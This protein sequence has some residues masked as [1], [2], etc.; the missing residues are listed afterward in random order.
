VSEVAPQYAPG[1]ATRMSDYARQVEILDAGGLSIGGAPLH[2]T[3]RV[4]LDGQPVTLAPTGC[5]PRG[6]EPSWQVIG[7]PDEGT[8]LALRVYARDVKVTRVAASMNQVYLG[9][10]LLLVPF[11]GWLPGPGLPELAG[12]APDSPVTVY[13]HVAEVLIRS[14]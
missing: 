10:Q 9:G 5:G 11:E 14:G 6:V 13:L 7:G 2:V 12:L 3:G 8:V 4:L 1:W